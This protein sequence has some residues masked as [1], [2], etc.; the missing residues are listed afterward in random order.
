VGFYQGIYPK[1]NFAGIVFSAVVKGGEAT[2]SDEHPDV[3]WFTKEEVM[4]L[5]ADDL[6]VAKYPPF[7]I[8]HYLTR[9]AFPL[10]LVASYDYTKE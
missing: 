9:G 8:N 5:A 3:K 7:A 6:L 10:E 4:K 2:S 1:V